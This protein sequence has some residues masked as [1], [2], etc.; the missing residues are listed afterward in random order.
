MGPGVGWGSQSR[1]PADADPPCPHRPHCVSWRR[2]SCGRMWSV[3]HQKGSGSE[4]HL[5]GC[6]VLISSARAAK[7]CPRGLG[8]LPPSFRMLVIC[9]SHPGSPCIS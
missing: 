9:Q 3:T 7:V 8:V 2:T 5:C 4:S 1:D 6:S